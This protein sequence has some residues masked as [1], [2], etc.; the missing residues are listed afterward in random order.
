MSKLVYYSQE[1]ARWKNVLY[2][3]RNDKTQT[4]GTSA[5]G[6]TSA[7]MAISTLSGNTVLPT[8]AATYAIAKGFRTPDNGTSW[9][10]FGSIAKQYGL[11]CKQTGS[12]AEVKE[13]LGAGKL[14][15]ASM[16][17]GHFTGGG[18]YVLLVGI[19]T[20]K[21]IAWIDVY[22]PNHDNTKY[23]SD[24]LINQGIRNDGKVTAKE[25]VFKNEAKQYWIFSKLV[26][27]E[28]EM[29]K[30]DADGIIAYLKLAHG[31]AKTVAEKKEIGRLADTVREA[32]GQAK[33]NG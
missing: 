19:N 33:Q 20:E 11:I 21:G 9:G 1:D 15:I 2:S 32:S 16:G 14:V 30:A 22:D 10:Y 12:L 7:A 5:C 24:G 25:T 28:P 17:K 31:F 29:K 18:H 3:I 13:A 26:K 8:T 4:I 27:E 6:P 23:G